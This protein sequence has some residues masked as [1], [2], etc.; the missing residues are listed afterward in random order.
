MAKTQ[1]ISGSKGKTH[2]RKLGAKKQA[3]RDLGL[4]E[5]GARRVKGG[6][7]RGGGLGKKGGMRE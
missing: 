5:G 1:K 4:L 7:A 2:G 6:A 3:V